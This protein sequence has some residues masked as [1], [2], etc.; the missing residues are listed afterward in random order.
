[1]GEEI[2]TSLPGAHLAFWINR[3]TDPQ[4]NP[5]SLQAKYVYEPD[6]TGSNISG[7]PMPSVGDPLPAWLSDKT[8]W[9]GTTYQPIGKESD[10]QFIVPSIRALVRRSVGGKTYTILVAIPINRKL[11]EHYKSSTGIKLQPYFAVLFGANERSFANAQTRMRIGNRNGLEQTAQIDAQQNSDFAP[12]QL[13]S[14]DQFGESLPNQSN[15]LSLSYPVL[16]DVTN[17]TSGKSHP[18]PAFLFRSLFWSSSFNQ[19]NSWNLLGKIWIVVLVAIGLLFLGFEFVALFSAGLMTRAVT[20]TVAKLHHATQLIK[21]GDFSHRVRV[22]SHDQL[23]ELAVSFNEMSANI[24]SLLKERVEHERLER[25][26]EIAAC[27]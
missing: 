25:E 13:P 18:Y 14:V 27:V 2:Q 20:G 8:E 17:W 24:E 7:Q 3:T 4:L 12:K 23:G 16:I 9:V 10:D 19:L 1:R 15:Y 6:L 22:R 21:R 5:Q 11:I 26:V